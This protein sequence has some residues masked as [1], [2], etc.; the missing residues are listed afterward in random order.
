MR[1]LRL[2][3]SKK[4]FDVMVTGEKS[5]EF[6]TPSKWIKSRLFDKNGNVRDYDLVEFKNGYG[7]DV[8][9]FMAEY[10]GFIESSRYFSK[11]YSNDLKVQVN[12]GDFEIFLGE[13]TERRNIK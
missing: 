1:V 6:R 9:M 5:K 12:A 2:T 10:R 11:E 13:I 8:P 4:P 7:S 3:L